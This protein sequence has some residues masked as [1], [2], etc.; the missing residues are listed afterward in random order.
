M[1]ATIYAPTRDLVETSGA[2]MVCA[3]NS[4][5]RSRTCGYWYTVTTD[6]MTAHTAFAT[7]RG[8][9]RWLDERGLSCEIPTAIQPE[10]YGKE[11]SC[12]S[13]I[14]GT[15]RKHSHFSYDEFYALPV[16]IRTKVLDNGDYTLGLITLDDDGI[17]TVHYM[18]CN[19]H[20]RIKYDYQTAREEMS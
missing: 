4:E 8:L 19:C 11:L 15:Y 13:W 9:E 6:S 18:N 10:D 20:E 17:R 16:Y 5:Q 7:R 1:N 3:L 2:L 14:T 12:C